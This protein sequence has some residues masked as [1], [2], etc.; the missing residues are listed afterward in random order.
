M[1]ILRRGSDRLPGTRQPPED[2]AGR[3]SGVET[4]SPA[5]YIADLGNSKVIRART[6]LDPSEALEAVGLPEETPFSHGGGERD[7]GR[8]MSQENVEIARG[9]VNA[10]NRGDREGWLAAAHPDMEWSSAVLREVQGADTVTTGRAAIEQ[11]WDDWRTL[12]DLEVDI[13]EWRD[14][15]DT[16]LALGSMRTR[17][18]ASGAE[19]VRPVSYVAEFDAG[20]IRRMTAYLSPEEALEA[21]GLS[22]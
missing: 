11:F 13:V 19:M 8:T 6:Y 14:L 17:G 12:W 15:G 9:V 18:K 5:A 21:L 4:E 10:W 16:V 1:E 7:T 22:E 3:A 20:L 2:G